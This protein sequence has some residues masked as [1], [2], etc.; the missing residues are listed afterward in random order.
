MGIVEGR[1][2]EEWWKNDT[3]REQEDEG[4]DLKAEEET[5]KMTRIAF[6]V[7]RYVKGLYL[8]D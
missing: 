1:A 5:N 4:T 2:A 7:Q 8:K 3:D 6:R